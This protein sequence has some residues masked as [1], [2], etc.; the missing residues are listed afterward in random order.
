MP[1]GHRGPTGG[2]GKGSGSSKTGGTS[3][4]DGKSGKQGGASRVRAG[5]WNR[6]RE[7]CPALR[8]PRVTVV[9]LCLVPLLTLL[10]LRSPSLPLPL[11]LSLSPSLRSSSSTRA[12]VLRAAACRVHRRA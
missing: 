12:R 5:V 1:K 9:H 4:K 6:R 10:T 2:H 11:F 3:K 8:P 7:P